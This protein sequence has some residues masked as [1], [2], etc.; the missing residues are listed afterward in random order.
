MTH[1]DVVAA[2]D[3]PRIH[4]EPEP[5][6]ERNGLR[7]I[8]AKDGWRIAVAVIAAFFALIT[9]SQEAA[10]IIAILGSLVAGFPILDQA[11]DSLVHRRMTMEL[12]MSIA[13]GAALAVHESATAL[14]ILIFVLGAEVLEELTLGRGRRALS[15]LSS[16]VPRTVFVERNGRYEEVDVGSVV[17]GD[18]VLIKPGGRVPVDG[19]VVSGQSA[20]DESTI[21]GESMPAE[22]SEGQRVFAGTLNQTGSLVVRAEAVGEATAFG[23]IVAVLEQTDANR[24]PA[25]RLADRLAGWIVAVAIIA[26]AITG[27]VTRDARAAIS[28]VIVA[29]ACGVA[30]GTPLAILGAIGQAAR[31]QVV[32]KGGSVIELLS[33]VDTV[34]VDKTGTV[35]LG[36]P[37]VTRVSVFGDARAED[38]V[39][40]AASAEQRS[41]HPIAKAI[42]RAAG[43]ALP[44]PV[45][46]FQAVAGRGVLCTT[47][48]GD[49]VYVGSQGMLEEQFIACPSWNEAL[50]TGT[51]VFVARNGRCLGS[52]VIEDVPRPGAREAIERLRAA[53][54]RTILLTG[55]RA[56][57]A[58]AVSEHIGVD[59]TDA[60]LLPHQKQQRVARLREEGRTVAMV[61]DGI[62]DA[63]ALRTAHVGIAMG[64]GT[65]ITRE[66]ADVILLGNHLDR[67]ADVIAIAR[68]CRGIVMQNFAG[69]I[70][71]DLAGI[72]LA[73][74]GVIHPISA[75][76]IHVT[77]EMI[78]ILNAARLLPGGDAWR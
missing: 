63:P 62:N 33:T 15:L 77:S 12:S 61:G 43:D 74:A 44:E 59:E 24:A 19:V 57:V 64:S 5:A 6:A 22:K 35:T 3:P 68:R 65:D 36:E 37:T 47:G 2:G 31:R 41:E 21:T 66:S 60:A 54:I 52:I 25:E 45:R 4:T 7:G 34:V 48:T 46:H 16:L 10:L 75:A 69:T 26:A 17:A 28:V 78:F 50:P 49:A 23:R 32:V 8:L 73:G 1:H 40:L 72:V 76:F 51:E 20:I 42:L 9:R 29:G 18:L 14:V 39:R 11:V 71:I 67:V 13:I 30:A 38:L 56:A 53:G 70:A 55:D 58:R 27:I